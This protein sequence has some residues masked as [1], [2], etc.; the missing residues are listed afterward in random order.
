MRRW[1]S[2]GGVGGQLLG[3]GP[4]QSWTAGTS[5]TFGQYILGALA[6]H[7]GS[8]IFGKF[9][10]AEEFRRGGYD[11][12]LTKLVW[13]EGIARSDWARSQFGNVGV[14]Y[15]PD[16]GQTWLSQGGQWAAMQGE[17]VEA[18]PLDG[19]LVEASPLD[20]SPTHAYGR[21]M[22]STTPDREANM[23]RY[24]GAGFTNRYNAAY[25]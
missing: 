17:L 13:T 11:L 9:L 5:L 1:G 8:K 22:P 21:L 12:L 2:L 10:N 19:E 20:G 4:V 16:T 3:G 6:V 7:F 14:R 23:G 24:L 18:S 15:S 25:G